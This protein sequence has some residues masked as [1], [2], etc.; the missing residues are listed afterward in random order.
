[1]VG[2]SVLLDVAFPEIR[3]LALW[4]PTRMLPQV[5]D[6]GLN[7]CK[8]PRSPHAS[9]GLGKPEAHFSQIDEGRP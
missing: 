9:P 8:S 7:G 2:D 6:S 1:L 4:P 3:M 5:L